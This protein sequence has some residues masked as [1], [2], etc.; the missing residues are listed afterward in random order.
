MP[1][2]FARYVKGWRKNQDRRDAEIASGANQLSSALEHVPADY[3]SQP[4]FETCPLDEPLI[5]PTNN[6]DNDNDSD[7]APDEDDTTGFEIVQYTGFQNQS[8]SR[9]LTQTQ[10]Q[11]Q[12]SMELVCQV[13]RTEPV[14]RPAGP[15]RKKPRT[16]EV[17]L[18]GRKSPIPN[19]CVG[20]YNRENCV[21]RTKGDE[22]KK[23]RRTITIRTLKRCKLCNR[24]EPECPGVR[25]RKQCTGQREILV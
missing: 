4:I 22:T 16:C 23:V 25:N 9:S 7:S 12:I 20:R 10:T 8:Q 17:T 21:F 11:T 6:D 13:C 3:Q 2:H 15:K 19:T 24:I 14:F 1:C 5:E 18:D